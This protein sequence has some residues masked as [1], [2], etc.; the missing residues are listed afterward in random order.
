MFEYSL[1]KILKRRMEAKLSKASKSSIRFKSHKALIPEYNVLL[2][3][4]A[5]V[6]HDDANEADAA[7]LAGAMTLMNQ[8]GKVLG[9]LPKEECTFAAIDKAI[10]K[11]ALASPKIKQ[12]IEVLQGEI[13]GATILG[14]QTMGRGWVPTG[15]GSSTRWPVWKKLPRATLLSSCWLLAS[16]A[17]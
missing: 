1:H 5:Y 16:W 17:R 7:F 6:G 4:L 9:R 8:V 3:A 12:L 14:S 15:N 11:L 2:S 13:S 10:D